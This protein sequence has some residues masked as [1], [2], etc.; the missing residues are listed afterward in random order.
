MSTSLQNSIASLVRDVV[1]AQG[2]TQQTLAERLGEG[3]WWVSRRLTGD[4]PISAPELMRLATALGV[5]ITRLLPDP[6]TASAERAR[7]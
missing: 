6:E 2:L 7:R 5:P 3:Q 4:V 1:A